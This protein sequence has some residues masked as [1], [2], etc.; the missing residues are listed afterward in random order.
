M[1]L[2]RARSANFAL[3]AMSVIVIS[4]CASDDDTGQR[5]D[6][7]AE[8]ELATEAA[9]LRGEMGRLVNR[10]KGDPTP[11]QRRRLT[12]RI[13]TLENRAARLIASADSDTSYDVKL[14]AVNGS[15]TAADL[16][17]TESGGKIAAEGEIYGL[18]GKGSFPVTIN[19][20]TNGSGASI[21]PPK[22]AAGSKNGNLST[23]EAADFSGRKIVGL[24]TVKGPG[25]QSFTGVGD[26]GK[27]SPLAARAV[28]VTRK[29][30]GGPIACGIPSSADIAD[31]SA[32]PIVLAALGET[33]TAGLNL[34]TVAENPT[35]SKAR[36][37]TN[38]AQKHL[39]VADQRLSG[40]TRLIAASPA[41]DG[42]VSEQDQNLGQAD[43]QHQS[44]SCWVT[45][46]PCKSPENHD[47]QSR[48]AGPTW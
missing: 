18:P 32:T 1:N 42:D 12:R 48:T 24:G 6:A 17:L 19:G 14:K 36:R 25:S 41:V 39:A 22:N 46:E 20:F 30:G 27:S 4:G 38:R 3:A 35:S 47:P 31:E 37:A 15:D 2:W 33:Q 16:T 7:L 45:R 9:N 44:Q 10:I 13:E 40:A 29:G 11:A 23:S 8:L 43:K 5:D 34:L 26:A 21:C 28:S